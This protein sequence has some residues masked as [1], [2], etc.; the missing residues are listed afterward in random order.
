MT[1]EE[2]SKYMSIAMGMCGLS[3]SEELLDTLLSV[4]ELVLEKKGDTDIN[5]VAKIQFEAKERA[6][7]KS[8][9]EMLDKVSEKAK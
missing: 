6:N 3:V 8:R 9:K 1:H 4:Y 5:S 7:I 2:K